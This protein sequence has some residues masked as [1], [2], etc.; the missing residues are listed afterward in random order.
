MK[1]AEKNPQ[2]SPQQLKQMMASSE[3]QRLIALL[4]QDGGAT[5]RQAAQQFRAGDSSGAQE[6]LRPLMEQKEAAEL[7]TRLHKKNQGR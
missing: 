4:S 6:L 7:L 2:I 1:D 3:M 5:L